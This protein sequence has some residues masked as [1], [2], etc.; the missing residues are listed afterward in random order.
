MN[1]N[2]KEMG[3]DWRANRPQCR[4]AFGEGDRKEQKVGETILDSGRVLKGFIKAV[5]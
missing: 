5:G 3:G 2:G 1:N 4:S